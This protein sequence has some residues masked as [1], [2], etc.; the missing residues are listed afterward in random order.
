MQSLQ[1]W[2]ATVFSFITAFG[3]LFNIR[4]AVL[5]GRKAEETRAAV[6]AVQ[7]QTNGMSKRLE[8][9]AHA[10][11]KAEGVAETEARQA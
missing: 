2:L 1:S 3:V 6:T 9:M 8:A 4:Q 5:A 7:Q 11:G 10:E